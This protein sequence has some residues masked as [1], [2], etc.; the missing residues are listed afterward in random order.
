MNYLFVLNDAPYGGER[1]YNGLRLVR[2]LLKQGGCD[3]RIFLLSDAV[4]C[5]KAGQKTPEG[6]YN[7]EFFLNS[8]IK[9]GSKVGVCGICM[10]ARALNH[11]ELAPGAERATLETLAEW[12]AW[13]DKVLVF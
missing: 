2:A 10:D 13:A 12:T 4:L 8:A 7:I 9:R 6:H 3:V 5:A 11:A 1:S